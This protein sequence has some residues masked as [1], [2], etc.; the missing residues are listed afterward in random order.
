MV[1]RRAVPPTARPSLR[2]VAQ[3]GGEV[4]PLLHEVAPR[5][6]A[7]E[8]AIGGAASGDG[9]AMDL[10]DRRRIVAEPDDVDVQRMRID[11]YLQRLAETEA[12][13]QPSDRGSAM[14]TVPVP[15][16]GHSIR[17]V[18]VDPLAPSV[19]RLAL[20]ETWE[21]RSFLGDYGLGRTLQTFSLLPGEK[22]TITVETW[23]TEAATREDASSIFDSSDIAAQTRFTSTLTNET[24]SAFQ[25]QGGWAVSVST[26][27]SGGFNL[28]LVNGQA[29]MQAGFAANHQEASQ[30]FSTSISSAA[31]EHAS[32]VNNSRRQAVQASS[33][34]TTAAG[35]ATTT[36]RE[37]SN[38][39]LRRVLNFVF[40][41]L[42]Q[43]YETYVVLREIKVAFY[44]GNPGSAEIVALPDLGRLLRRHLSPANQE[45]AARFLLAMCA[46]RIDANSDLVTPLQVGVNPDGIRYQWSPAT[47]DGDGSLRFEG[48]PLASDVRWR[49]DPGQL[50]KDARQMPG[51][52]MH[53]SGVVL[54]TDNVVVEALLGQAD[55]LDPYASALQGLDLQNRQSETRARD[56]ETKRTTDAL[57]LVSAQA[58]DEKIDAW[59]KIFP[60]EP[61]IEVVPVA[62]VSGDG[63]TNN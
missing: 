4:V 55:A 7:A 36:A 23:R 57:E 61:E 2:L 58:D 14:L 37:L 13:I 50:S 16:L 26:S 41:E 63:H 39:N 25:D 51:V 8:R 1:H 17:P 11:S 42:N 53:R 33:S 27:A 59:Q 34:T 9:A 29:S 15:G 52:I 35:T 46:Q 45:A 24:G 5:R 49:F 62:A 22:T 43:R 48:D 56:A 20:V 28:G 31:S 30:R 10:L 21:L 47:L 12:S 6:E 60:E 40:R 44:N 38:S 19:P 3:V 54:R 32:Q 18:P